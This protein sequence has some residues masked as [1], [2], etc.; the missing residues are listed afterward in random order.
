LS[1]DLEALSGTITEKEGRFEES[2]VSWKP[3]FRLINM[4]GY[5][6]ADQELAREM[7]IEMLA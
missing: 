2:I 6:D 7:V 1:N 5:S 4:P 3:V